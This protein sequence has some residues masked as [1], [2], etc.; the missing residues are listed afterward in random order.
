MLNKDD[1]FTTF[2]LTSVY[3]LIEI[4][5]EHRKFL[6]SEYGCNNFEDASTQYFQFC[7]EW[8]YSHLYLY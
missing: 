6:D 5:P 2:D 8:C 4:H 3:H 1:Y 7:G